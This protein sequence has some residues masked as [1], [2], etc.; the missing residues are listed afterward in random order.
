MAQLLFAALQLALPLQ[1]LGRAQLLGELGQLGTELGRKAGQFQPVRGHRRQHQVP[2]QA[3]QALQHR[4]RFPAPVE[5]FAAGFHHPQRLEAGQGRGQGQQLLFGHR[6]HQFPHGHRFDRCGQQ[7]QLVEQALGIAQAP[8]GPLGHHMQ[9]FG[10]NADLLFGGDVAQVAFEG[11]EGD[12]AEIKPLAAA[13]DRRQHPLGI[14]GGEHENHPRWRLLQGFEQGVEG[15]RREHVALVD[16]VHLPARLHRRKAGALDQFADVVDP[17]VR[18]GIDLDD[19]E[20][21]AGGDAGAEGANAAGVW[22]GA[23][24]AD[25]VERAGQ[26]AGAGGF[27][28]APGPT[29][30]VGRRDPVLA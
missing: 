23:V 5:Q 26:D 20:G 12:A 28:R 13:Q 1:Q 10:S 27:A 19:V 14:G 7:A 25:A 21:V 9:G 24:A 3:G 11:V 22:G 2:Q 15:G 6:P 17:G 29:E 8:L 18:G 30:Q 16:H 4:R